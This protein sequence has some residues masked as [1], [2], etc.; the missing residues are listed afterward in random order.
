MQVRGIGFGS[1]NGL[2]L[3]RRRPKIPKFVEKSNFVD[4][5]IFSAIFDDVTCRLFAQV[6]G[7]CA[8]MF[9]NVRHDSSRMETPCSQLEGKESAPMGKWV[10]VWHALSPRWVVGGLLIILVITV[11]SH[12]QHHQEPASSGSSGTSIIRYNIFS[13]GGGR[14]GG[15]VV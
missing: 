3:A 1:K 10:E 8:K 7:R 5:A 13:A 12:T 15:G 4:L 11:V 14:S 2:A 9:K 6:C